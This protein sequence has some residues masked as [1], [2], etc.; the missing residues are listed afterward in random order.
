MPKIC[1]LMKSE[2]NKPM[3]GNKYG[4]L[5]VR[6]NKDI[7]CDRYGLVNPRTGGMSVRPSW[8]VFPIH[9]LPERFRSHGAVTRSLRGNN[10]IELWTMG[11]GQFVN[12]GVAMGLFLTVDNPN[13]GNVEPSESMVLQVFQDALG[14][15]REKW[16][17]DAGIEK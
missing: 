2:G 1:R 11:G 8:S 16:R 4:M 3:I 6:E 13:H 14:N 5:G 12:A 7:S 15:T 10:T 17:L 9:H